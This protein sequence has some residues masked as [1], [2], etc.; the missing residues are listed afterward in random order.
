MGK[1]DLWI[2]CIHIPKRDRTIE[3]RNMRQNGKCGE[4]HYGI[5]ILG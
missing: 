4:T 3:F 5:C 1:F 2:Q